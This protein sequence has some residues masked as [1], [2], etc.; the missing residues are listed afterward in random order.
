LKQLTHKPLLFITGGN[1]G[2]GPINQTVAQIVPDLHLSFTIIHQTGPIDLPKFQHLQ[3]S[4][5]NYRPTNYIDLEDI[6][7]VLHHAKI[8][9]SRAGANYCQEIA[10]LQKTAIFIPLP[11]SQQNEQLKNALWVKKQLPHTI[12]IDQNNLTPVLL[13][14]TILKLSKQTTPPSLKT[15]Q[16]SNLKLLHLIHETTL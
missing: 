6:G 10:T 14:N 12:I 2:S 8:I 11:Q 9:I 16:P 3:T 7:W 5:P 1:Q 15:H 4:Y 13:K